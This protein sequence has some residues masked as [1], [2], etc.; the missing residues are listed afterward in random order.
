MSK[1]KPKRRLAVFGVVA[2]CAAALLLVFS[3]RVL[4]SLGAILDSSEPPQKADMIVVIGGDAR[5]NRIL[6]AAELV[7]EGYAP[8]VLVSGQGAMYGRHESDL[9]IDFAVEHNYPRDEFIPFR[10]PALSTVDEAAADIRQLRE[11]GVHKYLLVTSPYHTARA[12]RIFREGARGRWALRCTQFPRRSLTGRTANGGKAA[13]AGSCGFWN[14]LKRWP[15]GFGSERGNMSSALTSG[16]HS[17]SS[18]LEP[19]GVLRLNR[20]MLFF[21]RQPLHEDHRAPG[22]EKIHVGD[23]VEVDHSVLNPDKSRHISS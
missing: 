15:T 14:S 9:A 16:T 2:L 21:L 8:K 1:L 4:W 5:G 11:L 13:K 23:G 22:F 18:R 10:Y 3:H 19:A 20:N 12:A 7:R 17:A 6:K